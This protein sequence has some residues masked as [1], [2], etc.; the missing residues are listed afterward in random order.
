VTT[1]VETDP[2]SDWVPEPSSPPEL[3]PVNSA[4]EHSTAM[5]RRMQFMRMLPTK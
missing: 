4:T 3:H 1:V 5:G 2:S